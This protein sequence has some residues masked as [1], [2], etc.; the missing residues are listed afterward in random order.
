M[1]GMGGPFS[2]N[3]ND[4]D[5]PD[6]CSCRLS[7]D[8]QGSTDASEAAATAGSQSSAQQNGGY[9]SAAPQTQDTGSRQA[10]HAQLT[11]AD[12][13]DAYSLFQVRVECSQRWE[14]KWEKESLG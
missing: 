9:G 2:S 5:L 10:A 7:K 14:K 6:A 3:S 1:D 8:S 12:V 13:E 4:F 11:R